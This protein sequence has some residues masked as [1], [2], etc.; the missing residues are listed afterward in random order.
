MT[1]GEASGWASEEI[2]RK[3][4]EDLER[5]YIRYVEGANPNPQVSVDT[6]RGRYIH[7][8]QSVVD[9]AKEMLA[10]LLASEQA[11]AVSSFTFV[12][13]LTL[14]LFCFSFSQKFSSVDF[15]TGSSPRTLGHLSSR[16]FGVSPFIT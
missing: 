13:F 2:L 1:S 11:T 15:P 4:W 5:E 14:L 16:W 8:R 12:L 7:L 9:S 6:V 3:E 10:R